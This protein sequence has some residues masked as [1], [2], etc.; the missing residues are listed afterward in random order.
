MAR[1]VTLLTDGTAYDVATGT[2]HNPSDW[3][4]RDLT[5][6]QITDHIQ[7]EQREDMQRARLWWHT[8]G[9]TK[10]GLDE[11]ETFQPIGLSGREVKE[12][13]LRVARQLI[14]QGKNPK[15]GEQVVLD[16]SGS[17]VTVVRHRTDPLYGISVAFREFT[18][19]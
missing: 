6:F 11:V 7:V 1:G 12:T 17:Q 4:D 3:R 14:D 8:R 13:V 10:F 9:L 18:W 15:V 16:G 5:V 19:E 2:Y